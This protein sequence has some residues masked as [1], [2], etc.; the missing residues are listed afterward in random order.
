M[1]REKF[2][3]ARASGSCGECKGPN[4]EIGDETTGDD[5]VVGLVGIEP[6]VDSLPATGG[7]GECMDSLDIVRRLFRLRDRVREGN[8]LSLMVT[9]PAYASSLSM[10]Q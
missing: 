8:G 4:D 5:G 2:G 10:S 9:S 6:G 3:G 7:N 1:G